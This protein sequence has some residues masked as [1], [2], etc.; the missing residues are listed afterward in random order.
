MELVIEDLIKKGL[1]SSYS[2]LEY[3]AL[4]SD[5]AE[6]GEAT[7]P[8]QSEALSQYTQLNNSRMRR[9]DKT[10]KF[11]DE[12]VAKIKAVDQKISW[13][14]LSESWC[15]DASPALPVM[16]KI[17]EINPNISLSIILRDENLDIMNQFLTNGGM[18]IP[19][20]IATD[21]AEATVVATWGPRSMKATQ[22]VEDYKAE[23]GKLTPEFKQDLQVFYNK[24]KGQSILEDLLKLLDNRD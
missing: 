11:N 7:G 17:T 21:I 23:H 1:E 10:L 8:E 13:L 2:Y 6:K 12:A 24:D 16:N 18:S 9:W 3:R 19:K 14:V 20:L 5:L 15:G 4:V 22:L